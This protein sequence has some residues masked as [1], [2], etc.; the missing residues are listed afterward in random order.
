MKIVINLKKIDTPHSLESEK[1]MYT[2]DM[3]SYSKIK[4]YRKQ[5][6]PNVISKLLKKPIDTLQNDSELIQYYYDGLFAKYLEKKIVR[7]CRLWLPEFIKYGEL[8]PVNEYAEKWYPMYV[9]DNNIFHLK[10]NYEN[11]V[12]EGMRNGAGKWTMNYLSGKESGSK[13]PFQFGDKVQIDIIESIL[14]KMGAIDVEIKIPTDTD[15]FNTQM[16]KL[17]Y[18]VPVPIEKLAYKKNRHHSSSSTINKQYQY[19]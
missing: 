17:N 13:C 7:D 4:F 15:I 1:W 16:V 3:T 18:Y 12:N 10:L 14:D 9:K 11:N 2:I 6:I 8:R 19:K 5:D